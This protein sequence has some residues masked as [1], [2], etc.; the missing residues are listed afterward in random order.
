MECYEPELRGDVLALPQTSNI[1]KEET[2]CIYSS[3]IRNAA[4]VS[5]DTE[6]RRMHMGCIET[7]DN[8]MRVVVFMSA[9]SPGGG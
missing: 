4:A 3:S 9:L 7:G 2:M 1:F 6:L 8:K 5:A